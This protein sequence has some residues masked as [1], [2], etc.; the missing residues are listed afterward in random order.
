MKKKNE[1][2]EKREGRGRVN[3]KETGDPVRRRMRR[4]KRWKIKKNEGKWK[5]KNEVGTEREC[6]NKKGV[7]SEEGGQDAGKQ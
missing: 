4:D 3:G 2:K 1:E 6:E 5:R 7:N